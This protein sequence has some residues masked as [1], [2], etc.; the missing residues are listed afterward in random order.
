MTDNRVEKFARILVDYSTDVQP[1]DRVAV[2]TTT[3]GEPIARALYE[4]ILE[5]GGHPH[6]L[7]DLPGQE[8]I[9]LARANDQQMAYIPVFHKIAF[10]E[11]DVLIKVRAEANTRSMTNIPHARVQQRSKALAPLLKAQLERGAAGS[12]RWMSTQFPTSAYAMEADM[13]DEE[14]KDF[15]YAAIHADQDTPDPVAYWQGVCQDQE[16]I[17]Q[18]FQGHDRVE[19]KAPNAELS[20]SIKGRTVINSSGKANMPDGEIFTGP[21]E[22]SVNG[23]VHYTYPA[24]FRGALVD[25]I[26]LTFEDGKVVKASATRNEDLL[27]RTID[28][29]AGSR[30]V[31]EFAIGTNYGIDRFTHNILFDEKIGGTFHMALGAGYLETGSH[32]KS[33]IHWDMI[34]DVRQ[35]SEIRLDGE[36]VYQNGKFVF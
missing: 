35:D 6:I 17:A 5:R 30:Y 4:R 12:L 1:G 10:T 25:G 28:T 21:V 9:F 36:L 31:G 20:L 13:G 15:F 23:W 33:D 3:L 22:D 32:N 7:F 8:E 14:Y 19:I 29:D 2:T 18:R 11:F 16:R 26:E 27:L 24:I 34:C